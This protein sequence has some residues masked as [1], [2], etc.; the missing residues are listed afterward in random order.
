MREASLI[1]AQRLEETL[2]NIVDRMNGYDG[3]RKGSFRDSLIENVRD[4]ADLLPG[5]NITSDPKLE[6]IR[7]RIVK[8]LA[9]VDPKDLRGDG[10]DAK[11]LRKEVKSSAADI[12]ARVGNFG[13]RE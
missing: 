13:P 2:S 3:T 9:S 6:D 11:V 1:V 4:L 10:D 8:D 7:T 5:F 12:L